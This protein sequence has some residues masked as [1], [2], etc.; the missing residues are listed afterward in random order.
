MSATAVIPATS[1]GNQLVG[2]RV[3]ATTNASG[4]F[5]LELVRNSTVNFQAGSAKLDGTYTVP[6]AASQDM[7][8]WAEN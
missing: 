8:T 7:I 5:E 4:Y 1:G 3:T 2:D 6:N